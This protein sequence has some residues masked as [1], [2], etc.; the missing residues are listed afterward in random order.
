MVSLVK[1][2]LIYKCLKHLTLNPEVVFLPETDS[3]NDDAKRRIES[4]LEGELLVVAESQTRGR[5]RQNRVWHSPKGGLYLSLVTSPIIPIES[6]PLLGFLCA[7]A[8]AD[9]LESIGI[10]GAKLKWPNDVLIQEHKV[11]GILSEMVTVG[12]DDYRIVV[13]IGINQNVDM[14]ELPEEIRSCATSVLEHLGRETSA[15]ELLCQLLS[16]IDRMLQIVRFEGSF[17][18]V[19][20]MWKELSATLGSRVRVNDGTRIYEGTAIDIL[21][22]GSLIVQAEEETTTVFTGDLVH[23]SYD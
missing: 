19:L 4:G 10:E 9:A 12:V 8:V 20:K 21:P 15:E 6:T 16:S 22:D 13:G 5:G 3:T 1:P 2:D 14:T 7:C 18:S 17:D 11:A 23:L